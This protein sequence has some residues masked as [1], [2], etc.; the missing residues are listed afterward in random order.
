MFWRKKK[1][2]EVKVNWFHLTEL[3][4]LEEIVKESDEKTVLI[5]KHSTTCSISNMG[6]NRF[7]RGWDSEYSNKI[8]AYYLDLL[9][10]REISNAVADRFQVYHQSP[11]VILI[12]N[13][14]AIYESSHMAISFEAIKK[15][16]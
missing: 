8:K 11:Q 4:Q 13:R 5:F 12:K 3:N 10:F 6:I 15:Q 1:E 9:A 16:L 14:N 7:M 2:E